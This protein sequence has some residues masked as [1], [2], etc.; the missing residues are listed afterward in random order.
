LWITS[1]ETD[2][3]FNFVVYI[4]TLQ[5]AMNSAESSVDF[6]T[7]LEKL[8]KETVLTLSYSAY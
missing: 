7:E 5:V 3:N 1:K 2:Y 6:H 4:P 8:L